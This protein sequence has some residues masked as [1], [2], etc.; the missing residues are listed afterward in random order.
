MTFGLKQPRIQPQNLLG[1]ESIITSIDLS[2]LPAAVLSTIESVANGTITVETAAERG[3]A[4]PKDVVDMVN[5]YI[6]VFSGLQV[7][8][9]DNCDIFEF[10]CH[11]GDQNISRCWLCDG[12]ADC[13]DGSDEVDAT[14]DFR[15]QG[16]T[17][18]GVSVPAPYVC[19]SV[20]Q[21][22]GGEDERHAGCRTGKTIVTASSLSCERL[23]CQLLH[24]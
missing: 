24:V 11:S 22:E 16:E 6:D 13:N 21:C 12:T 15:C 8:G 23:V 9:C 19:D 2:G 5:I 1:D 14:C 3:V 4:I 17:D 20:A 10:S 18:F 7:D